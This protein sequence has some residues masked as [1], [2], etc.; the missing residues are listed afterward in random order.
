VPDP[1]QQNTRVDLFVEGYRGRFIAVRVGDKAFVIFQAI[2]LLVSWLSDR[3]MD[4]IA[5][6]L[7]SVQLFE[8]RGRSKL[9]NTHENQNNT[10]CQK[11]NTQSP[12]A[13]PSH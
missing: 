10:P 5:P 8:L 12:L 13:C 1:I 9:S 6:V 4:C 2:I 11:R 7:A 3:V